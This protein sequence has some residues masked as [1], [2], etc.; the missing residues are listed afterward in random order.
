M[1]ISG[2]P[3]CSFSLGYPSAHD[4]H[5]VAQDLLLLVALLL[6][7]HVTVPFRRGGE[8]LPDQP[9]GAAEAGLA[10]DRG[11]VVV[12][13]PVIMLVGEAGLRGE[14]SGEV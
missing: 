9:D 1:R 11:G 12:K 6:V 2:E 7:C 13:L 5:L 8:L 3:R 14:G 10:G 4:V